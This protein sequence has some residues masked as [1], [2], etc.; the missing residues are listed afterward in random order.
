[1]DVIIITTTDL[2]RNFKSASSERTWCDV[3][4]SMSWGDR[5]TIGPTLSQEQSKNIC[6]FAK[7]LI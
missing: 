7:R 3:E 6:K 4:E 1:M 2:L 5:K